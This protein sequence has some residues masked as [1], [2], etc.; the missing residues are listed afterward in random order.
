MAGNIFDFTSTQKVRYKAKYVVLYANAKLVFSFYYADDELFY[1]SK[2]SANE[3]FA[4][5]PR[6]P[7][8]FFNI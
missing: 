2:K 6:K 1:L 5:I 7:S 8:S 4:G 3:P